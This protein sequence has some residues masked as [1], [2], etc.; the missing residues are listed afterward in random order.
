MLSIAKITFREAI[1]DRILYTI[2]IFGILFALLTLFL[3]QLTVGDL[4]MVRSF[5]L[6]GI[7]IF[8]MIITIFLGSSVVYR[9]IEKKTLYFV[10]SKPISR[11]RVIVGKFLGLLFA[12]ALTTICMALIYLFIIAYEGGGIDVLGLVSILLQIL[13]E[14]LFIAMLILFSSF[15]TPLISTISSLLLLFVGH[16]LDTVVK[17]A[18]QI[19]G[20]IHQI[21]LYASYILPNLE[22][23]NI[24]NLVIH[25]IGISFETLLVIIGYTILYIFIFLISAEAIFKK[26]EL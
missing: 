14:T 23:F 3:A 10:L 12:V 8:G 18:E 11:G 22:K 25:D 24:R 9:E 20:A 19:G 26:R 4:A 6:A 7:Y 16:L 21:F 15:S 1:R 5:G 17:S 13:E 2:L